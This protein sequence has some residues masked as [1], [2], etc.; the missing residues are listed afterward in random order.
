MS[1]Y[2]QRPGDHRVICDHSGFMAW[3]SDCVKTWDGKYVLRR[4][5]GS[6]TQR[7]PQELVRGRPDDQRV[8]WSRP[9]QTDTFLSARVLPSDL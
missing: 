2:E 8:P 3:A 7:H 5:V 9:E 1:G 4:F 6:E